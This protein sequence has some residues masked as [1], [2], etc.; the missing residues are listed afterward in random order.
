M[1]NYFIFSEIKFS[2]LR[3]RHQIL[4]DLLKN[5][6]VVH[7]FERV[8][9]RVPDKLGKRVWRRFFLEKNNQ[10]SDICTD[11]GSVNVQPSYMLP[12][13]N[14]LFNLY[15]QIRAK[16]LLRHA[17]P[18]DVVHLFAN[19]PSVAKVAKS[20]K[21]IVLFD[22]VH[23]W[24]TFPSHKSTQ[25][26]N[27]TKVLNFADLIVSDSEQTL[28]LAK[29]EC[30]GLDKRYLLLPPGVADI[31][32]RN[33]GKKN[34]VKGSPYTAAFFGNLRANSD[35]ELFRKLLLIDDT[36]IEIFGLLDQ[37][38]NSLDRVLL[39]KYYYGFHNVSEL[40]SKLKNVD[41]VILPYD[42]SDFSSSIFPAKYFEA[43]ALGKPII[44]NSD[45]M[46]LP[47]WKE[48][49]WSS[50]DL[51]RLGWENLCRQHYE[52]RFLKQ[53]MF[54]RENSWDNRVKI[55]KDNIYGVL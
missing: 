44:S 46:H 35:L 34:C 29:H 50:D 9:S 55:L 17:R 14:F 38:L 15:N 23:N 8:P 5:N 49:I 28:S 43:M 22:I 3:Q 36:E 2:F 37:S 53:V 48:F 11:Y 47:M 21:C 10:T 24:W 6:Y 51:D 18:G 13:I 40:V 42:N 52:H 16:W 41:A 1:A 32:F 54:A 33:C 7:F 39:N 20:K 4:A 30:S 19:S 27:V 12:S 25:L 26:R 45:M 31:W